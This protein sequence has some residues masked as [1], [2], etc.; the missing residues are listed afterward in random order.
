MRQ[1]KWQV[2]SY[3]WLSQTH[4]VFLKGQDNDVVYSCEIIIFLNLIFLNSS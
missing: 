4:M 2:V 3:V 1:K